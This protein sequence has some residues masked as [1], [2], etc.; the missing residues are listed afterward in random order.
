MEL[1]AFVPN[2]EKSDRAGR[3]LSMALDAS[4]SN[5]TCAVDCITLMQI[6]H[7]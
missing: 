3:I 6:A 7:V 4:V 2:P 5:L 1:D